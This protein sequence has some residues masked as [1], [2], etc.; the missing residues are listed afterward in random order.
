MLLGC[1]GPMLSWINWLRGKCCYYAQ[2]SCSNTLRS[3]RCSGANRPDQPGLLA[4]AVALQNF[5]P[6]RLLDPLFGRLPIF[7]IRVGAKDSSLRPPTNA[8]RL[9]RPILNGY[10]TLPS[11]V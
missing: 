7:L 9:L 11:A 3:G 8:F 2:K 4:V 5:L 1:L 6:D 10:S